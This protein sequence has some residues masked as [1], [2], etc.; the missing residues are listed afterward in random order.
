[1]KDRI[2]TVAELRGA[3]AVV[4]C[5]ENGRSERVRARNP[6]GASPGDKVRVSDGADDVLRSPAL[7]WGAPVFGLFLGIAL[8]LIAGSRLEHGPDPGV[9]S[10][11]LGAAFLVGSIVIVRVGGRALRADGG[12]IAEILSRSE[13]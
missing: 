12:E 10:A 7:R 4:L 2:G 6:L 5:H 13:E 1:M 8:G 3:V 11:I 9:L